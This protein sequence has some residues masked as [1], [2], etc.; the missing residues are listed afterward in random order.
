MTWDELRTKGRDAWESNQ[1]DPG[2]VTSGESLSE[3]G[4]RVES[5]LADMRR[6]HRDGVVVGVTHLEP[7]RAILLR[8][9][10]RPLTDLFAFNIGLGHAVRLEPK[11]DSA[12]LDPHGLHSILTGERAD[13][14]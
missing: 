5:W 1:R 10:G 3:L 14:G 7:L 12:A 11:P 9:L 6:E 8:L 13:F 4:D 2:S